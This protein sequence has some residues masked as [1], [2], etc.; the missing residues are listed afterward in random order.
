MVIAPV[1]DP[2]E[3]TSLAIPNQQYATG[4]LVRFETTDTLPDPLAPDTDYY[5][6]PIEENAVEVY[7]TAN[8]AETANLS[9]RIA[10]LSKGEGV[11]RV[12]KETEPEQVAEVAVIEKQLTDSY[13]RLYC[14]DATQTNNIVL[15]G[16]FHPTEQQ[17]SYR[18]IRVAKSTDWVRMKYRR[19][20]TDLLS[21]RDF[22]NLDSKMAILMMVQSHELLL[23]KFAEE[24]DRYRK[25]A[26]DHLNRRNRALDGPRSISIQI[27]ADIMGNPSDVMV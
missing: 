13:A 23:K 10:I 25:I 14:W 20:A 16:D 5:L 3:I 27:N 1:L 26:V 12:L 18:R 9:A 8:D 24:S 11:Q 2:E 7:P 4:D 17:P 15:L 6:R 19:R 21:E 22:I